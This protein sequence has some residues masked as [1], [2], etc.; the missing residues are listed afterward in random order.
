MDALIVTAAGMSLAL[1]MLVIPELAVAT[2]TLAAI[3]LFIGTGAAVVACV[4][5]VPAA[6]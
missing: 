2:V 3:C 1:A 6:A 4:V 5:G